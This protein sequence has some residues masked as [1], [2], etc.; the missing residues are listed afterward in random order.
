MFKSPQLGTSAAAALAAALFTVLI[1][2]LALHFGFTPDPEW[3]SGVVF[4]LTCVVSVGTHPITDLVT[5]LGAI[6]ATTELR[7]EPLNPAPIDIDR[8]AIVAPS[9]AAKV[10]GMVAL[11][12]L[13]SSLAA[14]GTTPAVQKLATFAETRAGM[15]C[16]TPAR[17]VWC[18]EAVF[19]VALNLTTNRVAGDPSLAG[20]TLGHAKVAM[21]RFANWKTQIQTVD[22]GW[23]NKARLQLDN[24]AV[25]MIKP[26]I[27]KDIGVVAGIVAA[28]G[29]D[30]LAG[31]S[32]AFRLLSQAED[33]VASLSDIANRSNAIKARGGD[34]TPADFQWLEEVIAEDIMRLGRASTI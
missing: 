24:A 17:Q 29:I 4:L 33:A 22:G 27:E 32:E 9:A 3:S 1:K 12:A 14:C 30:P 21:A 10:A 34:P 7:G 23:T 8:G 25:A 19:T 2:P 15:T 16:D 28:S 31:V 18:S 6:S 26:A 13:V 11:L 5:S 20:A